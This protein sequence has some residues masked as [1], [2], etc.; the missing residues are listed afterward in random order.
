MLFARLILERKRPK[1]IENKRM[2]EYLPGRIATAN[3]KGKIKSL[4]IEYTYMC[5]C[6]CK[7]MCI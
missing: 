7:N 4:S 5:I 1:I 2:E 6:L 3:I